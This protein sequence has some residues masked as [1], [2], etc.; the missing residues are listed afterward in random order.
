MGE[1]PTLWRTS[2]LARWWQTQLSPASTLHYWPSN[3]RNE[4]RFMPASLVALLRLLKP[5]DWV[6]RRFVR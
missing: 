1:Y 5:I 3:K 6:Y 4:P 2:G